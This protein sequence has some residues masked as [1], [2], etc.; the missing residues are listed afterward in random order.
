VLLTTVKITNGKPFNIPRESLT[1]PVSTYNFHGRSSVNC[2][3]N[4]EINNSSFERMENFQY[5]GT[6][7]NQNPIQEEIK[8]RWKLGNAGCHSVRILLSFSL[9]FKNLKIKI[10]RTLICPLFCMGVKLGL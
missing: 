8:G 5:L 2:M 7:L 3:H 4:S 6:T 10:Y 9:V 1:L